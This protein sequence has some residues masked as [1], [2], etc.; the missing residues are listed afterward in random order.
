MRM[1]ELQLACG[2]MVGT[3][4]E[5]CDNTDPARDASTTRYLTQLHKFC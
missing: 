4:P 5:A 2:A 1:V 3:V